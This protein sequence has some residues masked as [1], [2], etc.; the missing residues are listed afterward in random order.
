MYIQKMEAST[1][2]VKCKNMWGCVQRCT[3][4]DRLPIVL[5]SSDGTSMKSIVVS[6]PSST[7]D[8]VISP[9]LSEKTRQHLNIS[10]VLQITFLTTC[11]PNTKVIIYISNFLSLNSPLNS[12]LVFSYWDR[13]L[14]TQPYCQGSKTDERV[15]FR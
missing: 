15:Q 9:S 12:P 6:S 14:E 5:T 4:S 2:K 11:S 3:N 8:T 7:T 13:F 10:Q 1:F